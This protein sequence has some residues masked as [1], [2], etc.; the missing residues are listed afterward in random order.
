VRPHCD[1]VAHSFTFTHVAVSPLP[2]STKP[3]P[4]VHAYP[5]VES[6][7]ALTLPPASERP[8]CEADAHSST[9]THVAVAPLP[10]RT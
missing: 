7:H 2:E 9:F 4:H 8:H 10:E 6:E 5:P 1:A 3:A